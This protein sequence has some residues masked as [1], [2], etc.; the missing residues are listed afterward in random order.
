V[1]VI[2]PIFAPHRHWIA[3]NRIVQ[4]PS[5]LDGIS[6]SRLLPLTAAQLGVWF[7]H[8][9]DPTSPAFNIGEY[10]EI[11]G[12]ID[13]ELFE[14]A[15]RQVVAEA[16]T[17]RVRVEEQHPGE[18][19]QIV[20]AEVAWSLPFIDV[21][22][23]TDPK[24]AAVAWMNAELARP[25]D[26]KRGPLFCFAL[27]KASPTRFYWY[28]R[29]HHIILDGFGMWLVARRAAAVYSTLRLGSGSDDDGFGPLALLIEQDT[30]YRASER[31]ADDREYCRE[32]MS[33][34]L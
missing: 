24:S 34:R 14:Q 17:L 10:I 9:I 4:S 29:Y 6:S 25:V 12:S 31:L 27:F 28:T 13:P 30:S 15:L 3:V 26:L 32:F 33:Y 7:A 11:C 20:E 2:Q 23:E 21:S 16:Q 5:E 19:R 18:P 8:N 1:V 22:A